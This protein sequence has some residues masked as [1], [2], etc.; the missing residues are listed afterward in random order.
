[1]VL[2]CMSVTL[3]MV[4]RC[5]HSQL[6][7]NGEKG[8]LRFNSRQQPFPEG[9]ICTHIW[10]HSPLEPLFIAYKTCRDQLSDRHNAISLSLALVQS[11]F[12]SLLRAF[13]GNYFTFET[14]LRVG[15]IIIYL[16]TKAHIGRVEKEDYERFS[17]TKKQESQ[18]KTL[19]ETTR[20]RG[21]SI[22]T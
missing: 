11:H 3:K 8:A 22:W 21:V 18:L 13:V 10:V 4:V 15:T 16:C 2:V 20:V 6:Q 7:P 9:I 19:T 12:L 14:Q 17:S 5:I 1:M